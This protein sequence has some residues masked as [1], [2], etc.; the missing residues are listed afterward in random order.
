MLCPEEESPERGRV[1]KLEESIATIA[2]QYYSSRIKET[3]NI[4]AS[5]VVSLGKTELEDREECVK[6]H[7]GQRTLY[8]LGY[9][10]E[11]A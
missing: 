1:P 2:M 4:Q 5:K 6:S 9:W 7:P 8:E 10:N 11:P 3:L